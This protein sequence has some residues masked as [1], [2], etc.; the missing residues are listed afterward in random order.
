MKPIN[1]TRTTNSF[2]ILWNH[3]EDLAKIGEFFKADGGNI[4]AVA[5]DAS[6]PSVYTVRVSYAGKGIYDY[7][8]KVYVG[9]NLINKLVIA[10]FANTGAKD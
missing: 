7:L 4:T 2:C 8:V 6:K 10:E 1:E 5:H 3:V 9:V